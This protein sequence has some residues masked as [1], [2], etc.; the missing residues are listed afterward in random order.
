MADKFYQFF[1]TTVK[2]E[3]KWAT[4][5]YRTGQIVRYSSAEKRD[6]G[7]RMR[8]MATNIRLGKK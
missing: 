7:V 3:K 8:K 6:T 2:G 5:N 4:R 1:T